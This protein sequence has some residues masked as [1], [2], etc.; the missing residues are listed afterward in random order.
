MV[1]TLL[2]QLGITDQEWWL[3]Y[4]LDGIVGA[5]VGG[6]VT[7][8]A[9]LLTLRHERLLAA[10]DRAAE[11]AARVQSTAW[12]LGKAFQANPED[13]DHWA[14][15]AHEVH[16]ATILMTS[17]CWRRWPALRDELGHAMDELETALHRQPRAPHTDEVL[18]AVAGVAGSASS[19]QIDPGA[20]RKPA[21]KRRSEKGR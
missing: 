7:A 10:E 20:Y 3:Q 16:E 8:G 1:S 18:A 19:W 13:V 15:M 5:M 4:G 14:P 21:S 12:R 11:T 17:A 6:L 2:G 9:V